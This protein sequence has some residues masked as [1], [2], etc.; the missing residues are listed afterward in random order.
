MTFWQK[1]VSRF[2]K[3]SQIDAENP[4]REFVY[5]DDTSVYSLVA[6]YGGMIRIQET[7]TNSATSKI[8][9]G[10]SFSSGFMANESELNAS[11][12]TT[13]GQE[14]QVLRK[15]VIQSQFKDL[16]DVQRDALCIPPVTH[17]DPASKISRSDLSSPPDDFIR[18]G[19]LVDPK[20][21]SR[22]KLLEV[23]VRLGTEPIFQL[24][25]IVETLLK[26]FEGEL[27]ELGTNV[28][29]AELQAVEKILSRFLVG[30]VPIRG[31]VL[32]YKVVELEGVQWI[33]HN[34]FLKSVPKDSM[35]TKADLFVVGVAEHSLF[36][37]DIRRVLFSDGIFRVF[38]RIAVDGIQDS[39]TP[40]KLAEVFESVFP[41][42]GKELNLSNLDAFHFGRDGTQDHSPWTYEAKRRALFSYINSVVREHDVELAETQLQDIIDSVDLKLLRFDSVDDRK[43][44]FREIDRR[45]TTCLD[46]E[47]CHEITAMC[48]GFVTIEHGQSNSLGGSRVIRDDQVATT[49][50]KEERYV[51]AEFIAIYW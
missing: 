51:D 24:V 37:K 46:L 34:D 41:D 28:P 38:V 19:W 50:G 20:S 31:H 44:V 6:S 1:L 27:T 15:A 40:V 25:T 2:V 29:T 23:E 21:L 33:V 30:L 45:L 43:N 10:A 16:Y 5:L 9:V 39:W 18:N 26:I 13:R 11:L 7:Q 42:I 36:W 8:G 48:R 4:L 35:G 12:A 32:N 47:L 49:L 14:H 17:K 22:G 3:G